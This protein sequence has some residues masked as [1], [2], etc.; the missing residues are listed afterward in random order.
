M[1]KIIRN[2]VALSAALAI[3]FG[4]GCYYE[5]DLR[6]FVNRQPIIE[7]FLSFVYPLDKTF[8]RGSNFEVRFNYK[9]QNEHSIFVLKGDGT[10]SSYALVTPETISYG[11]GKIRTNEI[12]YIT[13][14]LEKMTKEIA[15]NV[16][17]E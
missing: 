7:S 8:Q 5:K 9:T 6:R 3:G 12:P 4:L 10:N 15:E 16:K 14:L 17:N 2:I 13:S 11:K 1:A